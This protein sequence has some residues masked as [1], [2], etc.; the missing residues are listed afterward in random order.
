MRKQRLLMSVAAAAMFASVGHADTTISSDTTTPLTTGALLTSGSG[1]ANAGNITIDTGDSLKISTTE[2]AAITIDDSSYVYSNGT[3]KNSG[4]STAYGLHIDVSTNP[5]LTGASFTNAAGSTITGSGI[6]LDSSS[7]LQLTGDGTVKYGLYFDSTNGSGTYT[8]NVTMYGGA[9]TIEGASS[10]AF[11]FTSGTTFNGNVVLDSSSSITMSGGSSYA[12]NFTSSS[13]F[14]GNL[15]MGS[16]SSITMSDNTNTAIYMA[17]SSVFTGDVT[18]GGTILLHPEDIRSTTS[19]SLQGVLMQGTVTGNVAVAAG[20]VIEAIGASARGMT[21]EGKGVTGTVTIAGT[22]ETLGYLS[23]Y[24]SSSSTS[25]YTST[26]NTYPE[27]GSALSIGATITSGLMVSGPSYSSDST[28][29]GTISASGTNAALSITPGNNASV[30][31]SASLTIGIYKY[32][33]DY[34]TYA[35]GFSFYNRGSISAAPMNA[36]NSAETLYIGGTSAY[37]TLLTGGFYNT[38]KI[39][40]A[41]TTNDSKAAVVTA[42]AIYLDSYSYLDNATFDYTTA[43]WGDA[44]LAG[45]NTD[46]QAA[47]VNSNVASSGT[48]SASTSGYKAGAAMAVYIAQYASVPTIINSGTITAS[49]LTLDQ[50]LTTTISSTSSYSEYAVAIYDGSGT[51]TAI[52]NTGT[53]SAYAGVGSSTSSITQL[54]S[55]K[56]IAIAIDLSSGNTATPSGSGVTINERASATS[57]SAIVGDIYFGTGDN[58]II[59]IQGTSTTYTASIVGNIAYGATGSNAIVDTLQI[60]AYGVVKG[61]VTA[62]SGPGVNVTVASNGAL[63]LLN[64][65]TSLNAATVHVAD[66]GALSIGVSQSLADTGAIASK[67]TVILDKGSKL[68]LAYSS[69]VPQ[70]TNDFTLIT[71]PYGDLQIDTSTISVTNTYLTKNVNDSGSLPFLFK[72]ANLEVT[73]SATAGD[74]LVLHVTPKTS[75]ELGLVGYAKQLFPYVNSALAVDNSLGTAMIYSVYNAAGAQSAY[76]AFAPNVTGGDRAVAVSITDSATGPI[77]ARQR[78]LLMYAH[79][80]VGTS[81]WANEFVQMIKDPG[82]GSESLEGTRELS[83]FKD[84]GFGLSVGVDSGSPKYGWYGG[85]LTFYAGDVGELKRNSKTNEQWLILSG[86]S[87]WRGKGLFFNSK[88]DLGYG[89]FDGKRSIL[90]TS[91]VTT[92]STYTYSRTA[93]NKREGALLSGGF[94]TGAYLNYGATTFAPTLSVDGLMMRENGYTEYNPGTATDGDAFDLKVQ[95]YYAKSLRAFMGLDV[96]YDVNLFDFYLQPELRAGYRYDFMSDPQKLKIAFAYSDV[97]GATPAAGEQFTIIG[98]DP[99]KGSLVLGGSLAATTDAWTLG[100]HF[101]FLRGSNGMIQETGTLSIVG[102]I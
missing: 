101:D 30:S 95:P 65:T 3:I 28:S 93:S 34:D 31:Q 86:Y 16:S 96:R 11:Y 27:A 54:D 61:K 73:S 42:T 67:G 99:A 36:D 40:A 64:D 45:K 21:I 13:T 4:V 75:A 1:T 87:V 55:N 43:T 102:K 44:S 98:P 83:G 88:L 77:A 100:F 80:P 59:D 33:G 8:G 24:D 22:I 19:S 78:S 52:T 62:G 12:F 92:G 10:D 37:P 81:M 5:I 38:G 47:F 82:Q 20:G 17:S 9:I 41:A 48:I 66:S 58:Q 60:G 51:L 56:Q 91:A 39:T 71:A 89:K 69:F 74:A 14:T 6:Y 15:T 26:I 76:S 57:S 90:L 49:A 2:I 35:P 72:S 85:A 29:S 7:S 25:Y 50:T 97:S 68:Y 23:T 84:S 79:D 46:E 70:G 53:I 18:L 63:Y 94:S 32:E